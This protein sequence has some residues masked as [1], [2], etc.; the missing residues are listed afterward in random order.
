MKKLSPPR[1]RLVLER[2]IVRVLA[3]ELRRV[4]A[5]WEGDDNTACTGNETGCAGSTHCDWPDR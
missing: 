2:E 4:A 1:A 3:T 5:G